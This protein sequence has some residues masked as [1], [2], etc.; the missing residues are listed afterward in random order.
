MRV[1]HAWA[2]TACLALAA[3]AS[4]A[5][6]ASGASGAASGASAAVAAP[7]P[8][9]D[10]VVEARL[11]ALARELRCLVCQNESLADSQAGLAEDLR[12]EMRG[13]IVAGR[14]DAE[15]VDFL[16]GRY[17]DFVRYRPPLAP[18]TWLLWGGPALGVAGGLALLAI[19]V[20]RRRARPAQ[21]LDDAERAR[22]AA[23]LA[24]AE[25]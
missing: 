11:L 14:S 24:E 13:L 12:R 6:P 22:L 18:R 1:W 4:L 16:V 3:G 2:M 17:G 9:P 21:P 20:R 8:P 23:L 10:P 25:R 5:Q 19:A 7:L 15:I